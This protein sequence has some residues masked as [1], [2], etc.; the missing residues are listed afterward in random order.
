MITPTFVSVNFSENHYKQPLNR[1]FLVFSTYLMLD[2]CHYF[3][4]NDTFTS[5]YHNKETNGPN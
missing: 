1:I 3:A 2:T 5:F 4:N